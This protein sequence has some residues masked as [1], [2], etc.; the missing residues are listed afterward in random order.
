MATQ[1]RKSWK[2]LLIGD[3]CVDV[4]HYGVCER[5]SPEAPVPV[6]KQLRKE[7]KM[8]MSS[9]VRMN[10]KAFGVTVVH[11]H[12]REIIEKHRLIDNRFNHHLLRYDVGEDHL[13]EEINLSRLEK[14]KNVDAVVV[15]DYDKGFLRHKSITQICEMFKDVPIFVDTKKNKLNCYSNC[16]L[17]INEKEFK[18]IKKMPV[19]C[20]FI[21]T[22]GDRGALYQHEVHPTIKTEVFDVCGAGDVFLSALVYGFLKTN[23]MK[24][25][26]A[27]ANKCASFSV[28]KM[29]TYVMSKD[30]LKNLGVL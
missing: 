3:H 20:D 17:K 1:Q 21:V 27:I 28:G 13:T 19:G 14:V 7:T 9:N 15:S 4:Y 2:V 5:L 26:I 23:D 18:E 22:L 24:E 16:V 8:G 6:L 12:N 11:E 10:L 30:D 25:A 29:G